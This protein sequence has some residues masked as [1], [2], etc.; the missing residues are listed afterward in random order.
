FAG[1]TE[2]VDVDKGAETNHLVVGVS[3]VRLGEVF[4]FDAELAD[5]PGFFHGPGQGGE[6]NLVLSSRVTTLT[7]NIVIAAPRR[8]TEYVLRRRRR[9]DARTEGR[10][11]DDIRDRP[12]AAGV[13]RGWRS[14]GLLHESCRPFR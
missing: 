14:D 6:K 13:R 7:G 2:F 3:W 9:A 10:S 4:G 5:A 12:D 11:V 1:F 8:L